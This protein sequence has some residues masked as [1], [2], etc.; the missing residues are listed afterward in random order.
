MRRTNA[1]IQYY[2]EGECEKKLIKTLIEN[3]LVISGQID[4]LNPVQEH[5]KLTHL[6]KLPVKTI[7]V[8]LFDTDTDN[9]DILKENLKFLSNH[10]NIKRFITIPQVPNLEKEL[11]RCTDI[12]RI[13]DLINCE[14]DSDFKG[15]FID[16]KRLYEK[17]QAH[18]FDFN[19]LWSSEPD[20][21]F[22]KA[23]IKNQS[24]QIKLV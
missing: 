22:Q 1:R 12:R 23:G 16:E 5:I 24:G 19:C 7:V 18:C 17:L 21:V 14:H 10:S 2:V 15:A 11:I 8:L 9:V 20:L 4:V 13:R 3:N 6:R